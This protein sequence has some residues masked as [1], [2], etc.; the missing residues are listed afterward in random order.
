MFFRRVFFF[1]FVLLFA[2]ALFGIY[3]RNQS[4]YQAG[5][6]QGYVAGQQ[7]VQAAEDGTAVVPAPAPYYPAP[8]HPGFGFFGFFIRGFIFFFGFMLLMG[9]LFGRRRRHRRH[10]RHWHYWRQEWPE[11]WGKSGNK[12]PWFDDDADEPVM[13]A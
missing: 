5:Y 12:P 10:G 3:G 4:Q 1:I 6:A 9:L 8:Y 13:K 2:G 11:Q 7:A